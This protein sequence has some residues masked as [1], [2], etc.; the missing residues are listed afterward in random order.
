MTLHSTPSCPV[1][2]FFAGVQI[3]TFC[4]ACC[5]NAL[6]S[7]YS[8]QSEFTN[9]SK[10]NKILTAI[11]AKILSDVFILN[12]CQVHSVLLN[13]L[14]RVVIKGGSFQPRSGVNF[15]DICSVIVAVVHHIYCSEVKAQGLDCLG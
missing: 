13:H 4:L 5:S 8:H 7:A 9:M 11:K 15:Q 1:C 6:L 12:T 10:V 14:F 2:S 3:T